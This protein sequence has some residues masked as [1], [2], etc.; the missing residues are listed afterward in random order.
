MLLGK[1]ITDLRSC[2]HTKAL[3]QNPVLIAFGGPRATGNRAS[4]PRRPV[5]VAKQA[6]Y[7]SCSSRRPCRIL[8][9]GIGAGKMATVSILQMRKLKVRFFFKKASKQN[10]FL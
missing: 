3:R 8:Y 5:C 10:T 2:L 1:G 7:K 9:H 4:F 6:Y